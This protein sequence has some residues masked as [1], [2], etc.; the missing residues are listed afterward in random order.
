MMTKIIDLA[1][2]VVQLAKL[3]PKVRRNAEESQSF[4]LSCYGEAVGSVF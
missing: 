2:K 1:W 3:A 4:L